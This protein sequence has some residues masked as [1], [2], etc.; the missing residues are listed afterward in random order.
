MQES[1]EERMQ[2]GQS[3][4][5][6]IG[7]SLGLNE[8]LDVDYQTFRDAQHALVYSLA[9]RPEYLPTGL[10]DQAIG[11]ILSDVASTII[12]VLS[13]A[14][15][16]DARLLDLLLLTAINSELAG[17]CRAGTLSPQSLR[18]VEA[19]IEESRRLGAEIDQFMQSLDGMGPE[20]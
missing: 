15:G 2:N 12:A 9:E 18:A 10:D 8:L 17:I 4:L 5:Q 1:E 6:S 3:F 16:Q 19:E 7:G 11:T 20:E 14:R 13:A